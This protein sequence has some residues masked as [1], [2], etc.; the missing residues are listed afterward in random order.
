MMDLINTAAEDLSAFKWVYCEC[1]TVFRT[2]C[3]VRFTN[4][5]LSKHSHRGASCATIDDSIRTCI[6]FDPNI[7]KKFYHIEQFSLHI[8]RNNKRFRMPF[9]VSLLPIHYCFTK[10]KK[11][12]DP[13][14][15]ELSPIN[16]MLWSIQELKSTWL[17]RYAR[18]RPQFWAAFYKQQEAIKSWFSCSIYCIHSNLIR[19]AHCIILM[20]KHWLC[21]FVCVCVC[22]LDTHTHTYR[23]NVCGDGRTTTPV[24]LALAR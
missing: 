18:I 14:A 10:K 4:R 12:I 11:K 19:C 6:S 17:Y 9:A 23:F 15:P 16:T 8:F 24:Y 2:V 5:Q 7:N 1:T 3:Q 21:R 13:K 20:L 22:A